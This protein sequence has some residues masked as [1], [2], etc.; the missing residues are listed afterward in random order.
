MGIFDFAHKLFGTA[1]KKFVYV[2]NGNKHFVEVDHYRGS[3]KVYVSF[4]SKQMFVREKKLLFQEFR[5]D[6]VVM[7]K[8]IVV[9]GVRNF[10]NVSS[11]CELSLIRDATS[12]SAF[13]RVSCRPP[14]SPRRD[15]A[16][17][18]LLLFLGNHPPE[19]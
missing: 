7:G 19:R 3:G 17:T 5:F 4:D 18:F 10:A 13:S 16:F 14:H 11:L 8:P 2:E 12:L 15:D 9:T 6:S 1:R